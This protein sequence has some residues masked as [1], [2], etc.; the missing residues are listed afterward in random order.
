[1]E[2]KNFQGE[3]LS[4][5]S[6]VPLLFREMEERMQERMN[7]IMKQLERTND[8]YDEFRTTAEN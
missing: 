8:R 2:E 6:D 3:N 4:Q 7:V 1:M 5:P